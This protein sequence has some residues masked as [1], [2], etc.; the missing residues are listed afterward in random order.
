MINKVKQYMKILLI[1]ILLFSFSPSVSVAAVT[2]ETVVRTGT[3]G[4]GGAPWRL[5]SNGRMIVEAGSIDMHMG[6]WRGL[7]QDTRGIHRIIFTG[8]ITAG[9]SLGGLFVVFENFIGIE[10]LTYFDTSN[11][12][13]MRF[14]FAGGIGAA[15]LDLSSFDTSNVTDMSHMFSGANLTSLDLSGF[16]TSNVTN[17]RGMFTSTHRLTSL[18]LSNLDTSNVT[19]MSIMFSG[20]NLTN[21]DLPNFDTSSVT[22][23]RN[24]FNG[25]RN[26]TTL[27]LSSFDTSS[28]TDMS[29]MF[30]G[31][32]SLTSLNLSSFDTSRVT[33]M[34]SMF[35]STYN[36]VSLD[37]SGFD[38][39]SVTD[40]SRMFCNARSLT[41][42]DLSRFDTGN[43]ADMSSMF[44]GAYNLTNLNLSKF[45]TSSV[46]NMNSMFSGARNLTSL[47]LSSFDTRNVRG[48]GGMFSGTSSLTEL[49]L[50]NFETSNVWDMSSMFRNASNITS[51]DLSGFDTSRVS[52]MHGMFFNAR[53]LTNLDLSS[54]DI[55]GLEDGKHN[56]FQGT[57][58]LRQ[59][60]IGENFIFT[61]ERLR[62]IG[63]GYWGLPISHPFQVNLVRFPI[64]YWQNV[65]SGTT[66]NPQGE[67]V[68]TARQLTENF[69]GETMA[70]TW[71]RLTGYNFPF[72]DAPEAFEEY[73]AVQHMYYN[74]IMN[75][76]S[77]TEFAPRANLSRAMGATILHRLAGLPVITF[78]TV[79]HDISSGQWYSD[80]IVWAAQN[81]I[82][83]GI[84]SDIFAPQDNITREQFIVMLHRFAMFRNYDVAISE[85]FYIDCSD[86]SR[87]SDW[88]M[89]SMMWAVYNGLVADS[90]SLRTLR[91]RDAITRVEAAVILKCFIVAFN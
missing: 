73:Q 1:C 65:G 71:I 33:D 40:M 11:V 82:V 45:D 81:N 55:R 58:S 84:G 61:Q 75:G 19:D 89:E 7:P 67:F 18:D 15:T 26:L 41:S 29:N 22:D 50:S 8:P 2:D 86:V 62:E 16:D 36:L 51:L 46:T 39:S 42:L 23:M 87:I 12:T 37:L 76:I 31:A 63:F 4:E 53:S 47:N 9:A 21:L 57:T 10:G 38:T 44:S 14:M 24:M 70:D 25:T 64:G 49:D 78:D 88:A 30:N 48:M 20:T 5:Y 68:F 72:I 80:A 91:P 77:A 66:T 69:D 43:V 13:N 83:E 35:C 6:A 59:I 52:R 74:D 28:V 27:D 79:F 60:K 17:M 32:S 56:L 34:S 85:D 54:F 3:I 90:N